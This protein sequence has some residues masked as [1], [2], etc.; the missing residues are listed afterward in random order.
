MYG[1]E[2]RGQHGTRRLTVNV[3]DELVGEPSVVLEDI[4]LLCAGGDGDLFSDGEQFVQVLV[5]DI[6]QLGAVE[7]G[8]DEC[9]SLGDGANV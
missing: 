7:L 3:V 1:E 8:D 4:V 2:G 6:V 5:G 9:V